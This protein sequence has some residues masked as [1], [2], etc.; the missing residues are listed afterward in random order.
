MP[1]KQIFHGWLLLPLALAP[2]GGLF[3]GTWQPT[4][5]ARVIRF[6]VA[7]F[8]NWSPLPLISRLGWECSDFFGA[9]LTQLLTGISKRNYP[10]SD[11]CE[12]DQGPLLDG[13]LPTPPLRSAVSVG[14]PEG[15]CLNRFG[16]FHGGRATSAGVAIPALLARA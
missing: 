2:G 12:V 13:S 15:R 16:G 1:V 14:F 5:G 10:V 8:A 6:H 9:V 11:T 3:R 4:A 7:A